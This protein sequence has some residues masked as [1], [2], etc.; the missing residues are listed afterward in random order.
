[1]EELGRWRESDELFAWYCGWMEA[2]GNGHVD[3][4]KEA[5]QRW[6]H[7]RQ[8]AGLSLKNALVSPPLLSSGAQSHSRRIPLSLEA[9]TE[10]KRSLLSCLSDDV[11]GVRNAASTAIARCCTVAASIHEMECFGVGRWGELIP[12]LLGYLCSHPT[13]NN[14]QHANTTH[15]A[16]NGALLTL[17]KLLEDIPARLVRE[18]PPEAFDNVTPALLS[19]LSSNQDEVIKKESLACLN[20]LIDP[21]PA[22]F[23]TRINDYFALLSNLASHTSPSVRRLVCQGIVS[24]LNRRCEYL[25]PH[26]GSIAEFMLR[27]TSDEDPSVALD[28]CE[29]W[30]TF[31]SLDDCSDEMTMCIIHL[32]PR[33]LPLLLKSIVYPCEKIEELTEMNA[34]EAEGGMDTGDLAPVFHKSRV[35]GGIAEDSEDDSDQD[36]FDDD[37]EW[38]LRKCSAA[39]LDA[40]AGVYGPSPTLPH[41]LPALQESLSHEDPWVREAGILA[42]G[43][44]AEGCREELSQHLPVLH[45]FLLSQLASNLPQLRCIAAWTLGRYSEWVV[46]QMN[47]NDGDKT[48][49]AK[50]A[51]ALVGRLC[52][53][54]KKVQ[55]AVCSSLGVFAESAEELLVPYLEPVY[56]GLVEAM[57]VYRTRSLMVLLDTMGVLSDYVGSSIG[58]G[59]L[60]GIYVPA[61]IQLWNKMASDNPFDRTLLPLLECLATITVSCGMNYQPWA[62][63]TFE[64]SMSMIEACNLVIAQEEELAEDDELA[65]PIVCSIDLMDGLVEA[66]G[67]NFATLVNGSARFGPTFSNVLVGLS[68]HEV[69]GVRMSLFALIGDLARNA[70]SLIEAGLPQLLSEAISSINPQHSA[71]CNNAIWSVGE[72]CV[73]CGDNS[74]PLNPHAA[75]LVQHLIPFLM[76]NSIDLDGMII[77]THGMAENAATTMGRLACVNP[78]FVAPEMGRFLNG[79]CTAMSRVSN[80]TERRDA[81]QGF[82][83]SLRANPQSIQ[84]A[85]AELADTIT[86]ILF[87]VMSWHIS[88]DNMTADLMHGPYGFQPFPAEFGDLLKSLQQLLR[89]IK[90]SAGG[91]VWN[92]IDGQMPPN[93]KRLMAEVYGI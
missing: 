13:N 14:G 19:L 69:P 4:E 42:L 76:G 63:E 45:P 55:I 6:N 3:G 22:S 39:S 54:N 86:A 59:L 27:A 8:M 25:Q 1:M 66:L 43:A 26:I 44:I 16:I 31:A 28:A 92:S 58:E 72:V 40:L 61:L 84:S 83:A 90:T 23:L 9:A 68:E 74:G 77:E 11:P 49:V 57:K 7:L 53:P 41:L 17:R 89:D 29:F 71:M 37:N 38:T 78:N 36:E 15:N 5:M 91:E 70:P 46:D 33:L 50:V 47:D 21:L 18:S 64:N 24:L 80:S 20:C 2:P 62:L 88:E 79:W 85:G 67:G 52:D 34:A 51:E 56:R 93:V 32:F 35:R 12:T 60:P 30:L 65:D 10:I 81:F 87:A 73:R 75:E 48:L 82:V